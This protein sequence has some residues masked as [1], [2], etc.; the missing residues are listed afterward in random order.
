MA[1][2]RKDP[3]AEQLNKLLER[4][5]EILKKIGVASRAGANEMVLAQM[6]FMLDECRFA[7]HDLRQIQAAHNQGKKDDFGG[8]ISIG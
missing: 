2:E 3:Y 6:Q 7:Q 5:R 8:F 4:E 1:A